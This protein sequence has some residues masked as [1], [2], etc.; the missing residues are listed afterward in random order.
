[1]SAVLARTLVGARA[2]YQSSVTS[3]K[4]KVTGIDLF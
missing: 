1:M 2:S 4:L 3:T